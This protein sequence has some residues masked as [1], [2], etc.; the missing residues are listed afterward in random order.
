MTGHPGFYDACD[1]YG[2]LVWDDF[3]LA[4]PVDGP[5]PKDTALFLENA[6]DKIRRVRSHAS[7]VFYCG[8]NEG[9]PNEEIN[10]GLIRLTEKLDG[11]RIYFPNSAAAPVGSGGGYSLA[12]PEE[13]RGI[14]QYF[15]DVSS[16]VLRSERGIPNVPNLE[17]IKRFLKPEHLWP[18]SE[19]WA[20]HDWTYHMNGPANTYMEAVRSYLGGKFTVPV[21]RIAASEPDLND[22]VYLDY[23]A[24]IAKMCA[25]AG[26]EWTA[27]EFFRTAQLIN[28]DH[29]RGLF[30]ALGA[31]RTGG[32]LMW[33][34]QS[35]W[36]SFMWQTYDYYLDTNGGYFG[37]KAGN[38][39]TR[40]IFDPRSGSILA[41]NASGKRYENAAVTAEVFDLN[42][43]PVS[44]SE[45]SVGA[46]EP[47]ACGLYIGKPDFEASPTDIVFLRLSLR[48]SSGQLVG[49]NTYWHNIREYHNY[50]ALAKLCKASVALK[51]ARAG[52][53]EIASGAACGGNPD[54]AS[55]A[56]CGKTREGGEAMYTLTLTNGPVPALGVR[57]RLTG[58][59]GSAVLPVFYSDNYLIMMPGEKRTVAASFDPS[60]L[61]GNPVWSLTGWNL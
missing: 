45:F 27:E 60:R 23:K 6:A 24:G 58:E 54:A 30:D 2:I 14:K 28:Y 33:M 34:S 39:P 10:S 55:E 18:I 12:A 7:V 4:N 57:I 52:A 21:D 19:V 44:K 51:A 26:E 48:D 43:S 22:P 59:D 56:E 8:R 50:R 29:H 35:S 42:G 32:L 15:D 20:L 47:D 49:M 17:S 31:R 37:A 1:K 3:W 41:A 38:Q 46:I 16:V 11:T 13:D 53:P 36:P 5:E 25:D 40:A 61:T 9:Y